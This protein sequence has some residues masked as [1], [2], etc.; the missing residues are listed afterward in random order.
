MHRSTLCDWL[1]ACAD[2]LRSL[3]DR[4]VSVVLQSRSLHTDDTAVKMQ[5]PLT[6]RLSTARLW[7]AF[8]DGGQDAGDF[9]HEV[10]DNRRGEDRPAVQRVRDVLRRRA[11]DP[12][13][14]GL[15]AGNRSRVEGDNRTGEH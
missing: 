8:V 7:V 14:P 3:Y 1:G 5:E 12:T 2:L 15:S 6:H 13:A 4:M 9:T 10:Q 11:E